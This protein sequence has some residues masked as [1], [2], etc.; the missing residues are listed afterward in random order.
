M[1]KGQSLVILVL[2][3]TAA[4][5]T[6]AVLGGVYLGYYVGPEVGVSGGVLAIAFSTVG[7]LVGLLLLVRVVKV[8]VA[9][10]V[11]GEAATS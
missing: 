4:V 5:I 7:F 9:R 3:A 6:P 2:A 8:L 11:R 10:S 1:A